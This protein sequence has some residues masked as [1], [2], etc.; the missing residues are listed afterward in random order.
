MW[1]KEISNCNPL[2]FQAFVELPRYFHLFQSKS[3][4]HSEGFFFHKQISYLQKR[5]KNVLGKHT[6]LVKHCNHVLKNPIVTPM[7][8]TTAHHSLQSEK[9]VS[10]Q[11]FPRKQSAPKPKG[12]KLSIATVVFQKIRYLTYLIPTR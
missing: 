5:M 2:N 6:K 1:C 9:T 8:M 3:F 4:I 12:E 10:S 11:D 7:T